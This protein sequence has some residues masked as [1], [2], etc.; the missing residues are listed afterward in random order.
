M[1]RIAMSQSSKKGGGDTTDTVKI[2]GYSD[3]LFLKM[4]MEN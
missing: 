3:E 2:Q 1:L 4:E